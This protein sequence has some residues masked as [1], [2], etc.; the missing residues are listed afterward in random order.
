MV[1]VELTDHGTTFQ[2]VRRTTTAY[3]KD[4]QPPL[5]ATTVT[6]CKISS[7]FCVGGAGVRELT[8]LRKALILYFYTV[9]VVHSSSHSTKRR[10]WYSSIYYCVRQ[11]ADTG[12]LP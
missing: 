10:Y 6:E 11:E 2:I 1:H 5:S 7:Q 8:L 9:I 4:A 3:R 12:R